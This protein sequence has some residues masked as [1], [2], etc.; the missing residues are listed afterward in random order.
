MRRTRPALS[1]PARP[2]APAIPLAAQTALCAAAG[3][4][5]MQLWRLAGMGG[6]AAGWLAGSA[7]YV[8]GAGLAMALVG[9]FHPFSRFGA[10]NAVTL[11]RAAP[12]AALLPP[13]LAGQAAGLPVAVTGVVVMLLDGADGWLARRGHVTSAF[14]AR[15][16]IEV[17]SALALILSLHIL[18]GGSIGPGILLLGLMRYAFVLAGLV[19]PALARP[20]I[21]S[22]RRKLICVLQLAVLVVL[23]LRFAG[24]DLA[25]WLVLG[26]VAALVWSFAV[27]IRWLWRRR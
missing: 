5:V 9:R 13:L 20:L 10:G 26:A 11:L 25:V 22:F 14:G 7:V 8:A 27:D 18:A 3:L 4:G 2:A 21:P 19:I 16:D 24:P 15:F 23:Q 12:V 6:D 1:H 17:D